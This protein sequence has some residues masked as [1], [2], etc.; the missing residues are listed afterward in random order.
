M[1]TLHKS[2]WIY[3]KNKK[4]L[5]A[6]NRNRDIFYNLGGK[7]KAEESDEEALIREIKE[8]IDVDLGPATVKYLHTVKAQAHGK[9]KGV[10]ARIKCFSGEFKGKIK[11]RAEIAEVAWFTSEDM[12][13]TSPTGQLILKWLKEKDLID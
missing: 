2:A 6:R 4:V 13:R 5:Y 3:V 1:S 12:N 9:P 10:Q 7:K 8:E 11:P